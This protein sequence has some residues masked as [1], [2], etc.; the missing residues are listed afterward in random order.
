MSGF[1]K[2][3]AR[4]ETKYEVNNA[5]YHRLREKIIAHWRKTYLLED[6]KL[7]EDTQTGYLLALAFDMADGDKTLIEKF[8]ARLRKKIEENDYKL[9]TGFVGTGILC[10]TLG[11]HGMNDLAYSLLLQTDNPSWLYSVLQGATTVWERWNSYTIEDG[12]GP[13]GMNSFNHYAYG[14]VAEWMFGYM[15][16]IRPDP[17]RGGFDHFV[18]APV[19]D[20]RAPE[21]I[22]AGQTPIRHVKAH[23]DA[24]AGR[25][26][27]EWDYVDG[28]LRYVF[29]VPT[30]TTAEVVFPVASPRDTLRINGID[31]TAA[32]LNAEIRR[33]AW[34]FRVNAGSYTVI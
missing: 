14:A 13:V 22:P 30:G 3:L 2:V 8:R 31:R 27:S 29:T 28:N 21:Q 15:A 26:E 10:P 18:L 7:R 1:S 9:S 4:C 5:Y 12:F 34:T 20:T 33:D 24:P 32:E 11:E 17:I 6:G 16:G 19:P 25:I 23:Y